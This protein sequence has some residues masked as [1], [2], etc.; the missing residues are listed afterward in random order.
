MHLICFFVLSVQQER[1]HRLIL[2]N[3]ELKLINKNKKNAEKYKKISAFFS[4][5]YES[6]KLKKVQET[7][8][9][10]SA[11]NLFESDHISKQKRASSFSWSH[12]LC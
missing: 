6:Q 11:D 3:I 7:Y 10:L 9:K 5:K 1:L 2:W 12:F 4:E 8:N